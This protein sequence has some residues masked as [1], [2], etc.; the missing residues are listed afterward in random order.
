MLMKP[1]VRS[2]RVITSAPTD[3]AVQVVRGA[4][5][6]MALAIWNAQLQVWT[7]VGDPKRQALHRVTGWPPVQK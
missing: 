6:S 7:K 5:P 4:P 3:G 1:R 2:F